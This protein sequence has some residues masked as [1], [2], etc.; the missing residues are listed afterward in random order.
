MTRYGRSQS[1]PC[2]C[3]DLSRHPGSQHS[4]A[5][6][7]VL[8]AARPKFRY[9]ARDPRFRCPRCPVH[10]ER[11][12]QQTAPFR[13]CRIRG[14]PIA[15]PI[16]APP[17][18]TEQ[19]QERGDPAKGVPALGRRAT[20]QRH[21]EGP[22]DTL[23]SEE[24]LDR[25]KPWVVSRRWDAAQAPAPLP[26]HQKLP[27]PTGIGA[28]ALTRETPRVVAKV[29]EAGG[30]VPIVGAVQVVEGTKS[31]PSYDRARHERPLAGRWRDGREPRRLRKSAPQVLGPFG[32]GSEDRHFGQ[33]LPSEMRMSKRQQGSIGFKPTRYAPG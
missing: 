9:R 30:Q 23:A 24:R 12:S 22:D 5:A 14:H 17:S 7:E 16:R 4:L 21:L 28:A 2:P 20:V 33:S 13:R 3:R 29:A 31:S 25:R 1:V 6:G 26:G 32:I 27:E 11:R 10:I 18:P 8:L 15:T 19:S